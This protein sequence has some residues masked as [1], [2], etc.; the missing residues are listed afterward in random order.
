MLSVWKVVLDNVHA[1]KM[2]ILKEQAISMNLLS[3][4]QVEQ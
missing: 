1:L 3:S 4:S 2:L